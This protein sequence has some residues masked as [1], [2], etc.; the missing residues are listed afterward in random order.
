MKSLER[1]R[2]SH[3]PSTI[4]NEGVAGDGGSVTHAPPIPVAITETEE[5]LRNVLMLEVPRY[6]KS[7]T[8][9]SLEKQKVSKK[10]RHMACLEKFSETLDSLSEDIERKVLELSRSVREELENIDASLQRWYQMLRDEKLLVGKSESEIG[11]MRTDITA[12]LASRKLA[13]DRFAEELENL[14]VGRAD[15]VSKEIKLLLDKLVA[16]AYQLSNEIEYTMEAEAFELNA[17][18]T[19]NRKNHATLL[20][21]MRTT[22]VEVEIEAL[23]RCDESKLLWRALSH[24]QALD[25]YHAFMSSDVYTDP[26]DRQEFMRAIRQGQVSRHRRRTELLD[27]FAAMSAEDISAAKVSA[28]QDGLGSLNDEELAAMQSCYDG[29]TS[30]R[31]LLKQK[32]E[33]RRED[34]RLELHRYGAL[35]AEPP[36]RLFADELRAALADESLSELWRLGGGLKPEFAGLSGDLSSDQVIY[37]AHAE[38][39]ISRL[40]LIVSSFDL[41]EILN[42]RGRLMRLEPIRNMIT[43]MKCVSRKD[44]FGVLKELMPDLQEIV[45]V[46]RV[47]PLFRSTVQAVLDEMNA[48]I[49]RVEEFMKTFGESASRNSSRMSGVIRSVSAMKSLAEKARATSS[50]NKTAAAGRSRA[51][52]ASTTGGGAT[53]AGAVESEF[54]KNST[55]NPLSVKMWAKQLG[56][57]Y[58]G[59]DLPERYQGVCRAALDGAQVQLACNKLVDEVISKECEHVIGGIDKRYKKLIDQIA[60]YLETQVL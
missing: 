30:L 41:K 24:Q 43:K 18:V 19:S 38:Q 8:F 49:S 52:G 50:G 25:Q 13:L 42:E 26:A 27:K 31:A 17:V 57:L 12:I 51:G 9:E 39:I 6:D 54:D 28:V 22:Q 7:K 29:L 40:D 35:H 47:P 45:A 4:R 23:H 15:T 21:I 14:E 53:R 48:E 60:N 10:D 58:Y 33:L 34:L 20:G 36:L 5:E 44:V 1:T 16:I 59:S 37:D 46:E 55:V 32:A 3:V 2:S 56:I 11:D